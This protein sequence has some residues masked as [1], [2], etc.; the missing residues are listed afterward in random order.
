M[1][2]ILY[3]PYKSFLFQPIGTT[4]L[5]RYG[6]TRRRID[7]ITRIKVSADQ[8]CLSKA[9]LVLPQGGERSSNSST[10]NPGKLA[11]IHVR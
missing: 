3:D 9:S 8:S 6:S 4:P 11:P 10:S 1:R 7:W 2:S 5:R